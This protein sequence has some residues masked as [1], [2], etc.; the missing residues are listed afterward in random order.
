MAKQTRSDREA[1][2]AK[3]AE[4]RA[5]Q[6]AVDRRRKVT[7]VAVGVVAILAIAIAVG[8]AI[9]S[10]NKN[11]SSASGATPAI[12]T[13]DGGGDNG[14]V[15]IGPSEADATA[16]GLPT[17]DVYE[18]FQC[19][20]CK[21]FEAQSGPTLESLAAA[22]KARV[23]YHPINLIGSQLSGSI[24]NSSS[25][26]AASAF[27]CATVASPT[28][29]MKWHNTAF[30]NQPEEGTGITDTQLVQWGTDSGIT[31][32]D[33]SKCVDDQTY[34]GWAKRVDAQ[35][36]KKGVTGTPT[37]YVAGKELKREP[38]QYTPEGIT[39]AVASATKSK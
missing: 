3:L 15:P 24:P 30:A 19:P 16:K 6:A 28:T 29:F 12:V 11:S 18:D 13:T 1:A 17:V 37:V 22:G 26:R 5:R 9:Q 20:A 36:G 25:L 21:T 38:N 2:K 31:S 35:S 34:V 33:F 8:L 27:A 4:E 10:E 7:F 23:V 14:G 39:A 32:S